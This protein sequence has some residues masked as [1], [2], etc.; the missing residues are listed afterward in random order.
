M[1]RFWDER[2][3]CEGN[4]A[5]M[6][7][8]NELIRDLGLIDI[9]LGGRSFT[10]LNKREMP[11]FAKLGRFLI[12]DS[13]DDAFPVSTCKAL[14]NTLFDHIPISLHTYSIHHDANRFHFESM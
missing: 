8:F 4:P 9:P 2:Q 6:G 3:G 7:S 12:S 14:P 10:W 5:D 11:A 1:T 13:W